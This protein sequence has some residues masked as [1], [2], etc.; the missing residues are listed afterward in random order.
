MFKPYDLALLTVPVSARRRTVEIISKPIPNEGG[1]PTIMVRMVPGE[2]TTLAEVPVAHLLPRAKARYLHVA[3]VRTGMTFP[4]DMLRYDFAAL[5]DHMA[6]EAPD[7][8]VYCD[9]TV[10]TLIYRVMTNR[11][12]SWTVGRWQSFGCS[13]VNILVRDLR[14]IEAKVVNQKE[15]R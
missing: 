1:E 13:I 9:P 11:N 2:P 6:A 5:Y 12:P 14:D 15:T 8:H 3:E 10:P 7:P 4:E